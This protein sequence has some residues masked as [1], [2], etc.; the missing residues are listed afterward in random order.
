MQYAFICLCV[1]VY[2]LCGIE[3]GYSCRSP[4]YTHITYMFQ[5]A[6]LLH[7]AVNAYAFLNLYNVLRRWVKQWHIWMVCFSSGFLSSFLAVYELPTVGCSSMVY[8]MIGL[9]LFCTLFRKDIKIT[10]TKKYLL[11]I[12]S[13]V[14]CLSVSY[15]KTNSNLLVHICSLAGGFLPFII[16]KLYQIMFSQ[17]NIFLF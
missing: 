3:L 14:L 10:D 8:A 6:S 11:Y 5:H 4:Y 1:I 16:V 17:K 12:L 15:F 13:V 9:Y 2:I 7:L